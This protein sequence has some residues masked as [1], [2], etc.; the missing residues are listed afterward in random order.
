MS[1]LL[2]RGQEFTSSNALTRPTVA[3][4][5]ETRRTDATLTGSELSL[6]SGSGDIV[7][8]QRSAPWLSP[9]F[10]DLLRWIDQPEG[11]DSYGASRISP[12]SVR[13]AY[14]ILEAISQ[15]DIPRPL[16]AGTP[17]GGI[18]CEWVDRELS[19]QVTVERG[20]VDVFIWDKRRGEE[21]EGPLASMVDEFSRALSRFAGPPI[22]GAE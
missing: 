17:D 16:V 9:A 14:R 20:D 21:S 18:A 12:G 15:F 4:A 3:I 7:S 2:E 13:L 22:R 1:L 10:D 19:V 8:L 11:W 5:R 6:V